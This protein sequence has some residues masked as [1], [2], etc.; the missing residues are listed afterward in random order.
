MDKTEQAQ[1]NGRYNMGTLGKRVFYVLLLVLAFFVV[2]TKFLT[3]PQVMVA[4][5]RQQDMV[6]EVQGTGTITVDRQAAISAKIPGRIEQ[7]FVDQG[8]FVHKG[9]L[10]ATLENTD[11][12]REIQSAQAR[13]EAARAAVQA[14][15][16]TEEAKRA[17]EW[18]AQRAWEREKHLVASGAV[19]QEEA[20]QY[21][22]QYRTAA[23]AVAAEVADVGAAQREAEATKADERFQEFNLSETKLF[24]YLPGVVV[25]LPKRPGD[26]IV[27]GE[28]VLTV[29]DPSI[30]IVNA[31]VDQ[32]FSG[33]LHAGQPA[34]VIVRGRDSQPFQGHVYR[35]SPQADPGTEEMTVEVTFPLPPKELEIGQWADVYIDVGKVDDSIVV[36][37]AAIMTMANKH[38]VLAVGKDHKIR[39]VEVEPVASS[40]RSPLV[41]VQ[42]DLKPDEQVVLKPIGLKPGQTVRVQATPPL[43]GGSM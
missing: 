11:V 32:R 30:T 17:T 16:A 2:K 8:D 19:S 37:S 9:Q 39:R 3:P 29:A 20:D 10:I 43:N 42:G 27:P 28:P 35:I 36:P 41:A 31:F 4:R 23:S 40:P 15:R 12:R 5:V 14:A 24:T 34:T 21:E 22:E 6:A 7:V 38:F 33:K 25:N 1:Q 18:Q 13:L 26:A